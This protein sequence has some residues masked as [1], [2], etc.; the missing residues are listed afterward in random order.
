MGLVYFPID[1]MVDL[2]GKLAGRYTMVPWML[3]VYMHLMGTKHDTFIEE[4]G[5]F[6]VSTHNIAHPH[7]KV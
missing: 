3:L 5:S 4:V 6:S 2:Y 1:G 7:K